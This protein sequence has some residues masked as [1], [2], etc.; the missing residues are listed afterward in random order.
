MIKYAN[1][2]ATHQLIQI[3]ILFLDIKDSVASA[4]ESIAS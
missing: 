4:N 1:Y 2:I 3:N